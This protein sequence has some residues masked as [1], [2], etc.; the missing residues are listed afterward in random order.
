VSISS[1]KY[2]LVF[3][4]AFFFLTASGQFYNGHQMKFGKNRVQYNTFYWKYYRFERFD[5]YSYDE[6]KELSLYVA[7]FVEDEIERIERFFDYNFEKRLI[8]ITYNKLSDFKQSNIGQL[9][10]DEEEEANVGGLTRIIQNKIFVYYEGDHQKM[11]KQ[12]TK[13]IAEAL[14]Y[15]MLYGNDFKDNFTSSTLLNLPEWYIPGLVSYIAEEWNFEIENYVKDAVINDRFDKFNQLQDK[16]ALYAGH[17]FWRYIAEVYGKSVIPNII[18]LTRINK[19][20]NSGFLYVLGMPLRDLA[21]EWLGF[22]L[23]NYIEYEEY[24]KIPDDGKVIKRPKKRTVYLQAKISP[25]GNYIAYA[26][27]KLGRYKIYLYDT[28]TGKTKKLEKDGHAIEQITDFSYPILAWHPSGRILTWIIEE[29]GEIRLVYYDLDLKE[30][31]SR[32]FVYYEKILDFDYSDDGLKFV[33]SGVSKGQTDIYVHNIASGSNERITNDIADDFHPRFINNSTEIVFTSNRSNDTLY[34]ASAES[35][36][37]PVHSVY[38]YDY[39]NK[40]DVLKR[41][42]NNEYSDS[43]EPFSTRKNRFVYLS[44][45]SGIINRYFAT[46]DSAIA[47][48]DTTIHYRYFSRSYPIT[49]YRRNIIEHSVIPETG[50]YSELVY[51]DGKY[52]VYHGNL[53]NEDNVSDDLRVTPFSEEFFSGLQEKDSIENIDK[54][55]VSIKEMVGNRIIAGED[56]FTFQET[57]IDINNYVFEKEKLNLYNDFLRG[58]NLSLVMDTVVEERLTYIDYETS[59]YPNY[60]VNQVDF[61]FLNESYQTFTGGAVYYNPGFNMLFKVGANDLF[62]DYRIIGGVRFASDLNSNEY[63]FSFEDLKRRWDKQF[64]FHRQVFESSTEE[65]LLKTYTHEVMFI[66]KYPFNQVASI[67]GTALF[68]NDRS[69]FLSTDLSNLNEQDIVKPW[70]GLKVEF[71]YDDTRTLG[72][73]L[74]EGLRYKLF[75]EAYNQ[76]DRKKADLFVLGAD[77]RHYLKIHRT[78]IW[79]NRFATSTSFGHT[80]LIYYLGSLDNWTNLSPRVQTFDRSVP[81]DY[82][83]NYAFQTLA[84]NMR[85]FT[86]NIRNGNNFALAN[87][88]LRFPVFRYFFNRPISS[89]LLNNFQ[90]VGFFDVGTAWSGLHPWSGENAYDTETLDNG[91]VHVVIDSNRDPIV[92]GYGYGLRTQIFGYFVRL[93]W[94]WGIENRTIL[95]RIFYFSLNLDF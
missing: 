66:M 49:N 95:P 2:F 63:L 71:T 39:A 1:V 94:A 42:T 21:D 5:V 75:A 12:I 83:R 87:S 76:I 56:T 47:F 19:N 80:P 86:Q 85:G 16:D 57:Y 23:N 79:A 68:R 32:I 44:N 37:L 77:F 3:L 29:Q 73:N 11:K 72:L 26:S 64:L 7:D 93:D 92:Y 24:G 6:G 9:L 59:F 52:Q 31:T 34:I 82:S 45:K 13:S 89:A 60:L 81:I 65:S 40:S 43:Y 25:D 70:A 91:P 46:F 4:M 53:S 84:T 18:Y 41:I 61:S 14:I 67:R 50:D 17:S 15:E 20:V 62:E 55:K 36:T 90:V 48:I 22:Y 28:R 78:F 8:F 69:V 74:Y 30:F 58:K 10:V 38:I 88:E 33:I 35:K 51:H 27:N 54:R